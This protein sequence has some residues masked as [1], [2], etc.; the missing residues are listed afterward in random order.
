VKDTWNEVPVGSGSYQVVYT[1]ATDGS[2]PD[3]DDS[4]QALPIYVVIRDP[5][6]NE[7]SA[8]TTSTASGSPGVDSS[9]E[10]LIISRETI[11]SD[12]DGKIDRIR[13]TAESPLDDE[14]SGFVASVSG[15][16]VDG[17]NTGDSPNDSVFNILISE[18][19]SPNTGSLPPVR[20]MSNT[21]LSYNTIEQKR[22]AVDSS[23]VAPTD[24]AAPVMVSASYS[25]ED[26]SSSVNS[27]D[28]ITVTFSEN[29]DEVSGVLSGD[30]VLPVN[31]D[32]LGSGDSFALSS[33]KL[34]ITLGS[35]PQLEPAGTYNGTTST[36]SSSG[37][38]LVTNPSGTIEDSSNNSAT[39]RTGTG[40]DPEGI[41]IAE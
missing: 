34:L 8:Y 12:K 27:G 38:N 30:I 33:G 6:G 3:V 2:D 11:D 10:V 19:G 32:D 35:S 13:M 4:S 7:S 18:G 5:A 39:D 37:I 20:I 36:G 9:T 29:L 28:T 21:T 23:G 17:Y 26:S 22:V 14:F 1:V 16:T 25:D 41:D 31:N 15:H 24:K 40:N